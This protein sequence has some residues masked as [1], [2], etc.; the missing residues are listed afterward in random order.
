M[1]LGLPV[2]Q[3]RGDA[4]QIQTVLGGFDARLGE[5][6][7][8]KL[9]IIRALREPNELIPMATDVESVDSNAEHL[10]HVVLRELLAAGFLM[11]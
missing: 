3:Y 11:P 9:W 1:K 10:P 6:A 4:V 2:L 7:H 8:R 5:T